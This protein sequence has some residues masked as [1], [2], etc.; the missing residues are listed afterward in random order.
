VQVNFVESS[1][2]GHAEEEFLWAPYSVL[3]VETSASSDTVTLPSVVAR[4]PM[5][6]PGRSYLNP[7]VL[8]ISAAIDNRLEDNDL[9]LAP[10]Y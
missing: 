6:D 9:P 8:T 7:H 1:K 5:S 3:T 10:W 4:G 2:F